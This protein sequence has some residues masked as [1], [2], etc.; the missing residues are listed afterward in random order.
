V[1]RFRYIIVDVSWWSEGLHGAPEPSKLLN[2]LASDGWDIVE[3]HEHRPL[4]MRKVVDDAEFDAAVERAQA[5]VGKYLVVEEQ[6][7][8]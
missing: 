2:D 1:D 6:V 8:S 4:F 3:P 5:A 7:G